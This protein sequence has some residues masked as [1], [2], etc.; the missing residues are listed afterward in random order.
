MLV[1]QKQRRLFGFQTV[2]RKL[3][4]PKLSERIKWTPVRALEF[5]WVTWSRQKAGIYA[6]RSKN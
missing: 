2:E 1:A 6:D 5:D 3:W 4:I